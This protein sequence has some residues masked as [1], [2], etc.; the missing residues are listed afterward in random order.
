MTRPY[1]ILRSL[2]VL[3]S[4]SAGALVTGVNDLQCLGSEVSGHYGPGK[5]MYRDASDLG[6]KCV[7]SEVSG[8]FGTGNEVSRHTSDLGPKCLGSATFR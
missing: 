4:I 3:M 5:E 6:P 2:P 1:S 8:H 7:G